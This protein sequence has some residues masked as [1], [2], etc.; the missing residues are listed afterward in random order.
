MDGST[1][2]G[3]S[4][5][6][7]PDLFC[8]G[9][10]LFI[11]HLPAIS[12]FG[13]YSGENKHNFFKRFIEALP[14]DSCQYFCIDA[15][16]DG[17]RSITGRVTGLITRIE[18]A[19]VGVGAIVRVRWGL[20]KVDLIMQHL[21]KPAFE[22]DFYSQPTTLIGHLRRQQNLI[23]KML[24]TCTKVSYDC[25]ISIFS[26]TEWIV[27][28]LVHVQLHLNKR[29]PAGSP[30]PIR[31]TFF[32]FVCAF[33]GKTR[34][35]FVLRQGPTTLALKQWQLLSGLIDTYCH[36]SG[37]QS[38]LDAHQIAVIGESA[39]LSGRFVLGHAHARTAIDG[40]GMYVFEALDPR[41]TEEV[42]KI[43]TAIS[44]IFF[45]GT[46]RIYDILQKGG[47]DDAPSDEPPPVMPF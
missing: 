34:A 40:H 31:W 42:S 20:H 36:M 11:F 6:N 12:F 32:H 33:A 27:F 19:C 5:F 44:K 39:E 26:I 28:N 41:S 43:I 21:Y 17:A 23:A 46:A 15:S 37:M 45:D 8:C 4:H 10:R 7:V 14:G 2:Q 3:M 13:R 1:H 16:S 18:Q 25:W 22:G 38:P 24:F 47:N 9:Q 35:L 30:T 29:R